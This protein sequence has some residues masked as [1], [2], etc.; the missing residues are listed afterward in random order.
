[1]DKPHKKLLVWQKAMALAMTVYEATKSFPEHEKYGLV[2]QMRRAAVS[3]PSNIA[4]GAARTSRKELQ[5]FISIARG[6]LSEIDTQIELSWG[7]S[8]LDENSMTKLA[9]ALQEVDKLLYGFLKSIKNR[10]GEK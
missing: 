1:M 5:Q 10:E 3:I 4:E 9:E 6:S 2:S 8:Y 7:L